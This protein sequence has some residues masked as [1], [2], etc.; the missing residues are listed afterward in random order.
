MTG[1][2]GCDTYLFY[3]LRISNLKNVAYFRFYFS[4]YAYCK[5]SFILTAYILYLINRKN[6]IFEK[7]KY[8]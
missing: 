1:E 5:D 2:I 6:I 7:K 3:N 4:L 8:K